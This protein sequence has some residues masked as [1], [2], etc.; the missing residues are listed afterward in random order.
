MILQTIHKYLELPVPAIKPFTHSPHCIGYKDHGVEV[1]QYGDEVVRYHLNGFNYW[2]AHEEI[3]NTIKKMRCSF[4]NTTTYISWKIPEEVLERY[5]E[6]H[7]R[8]DP[9]IPDIEYDKHKIPCGNALD[10]HCFG[11]SVDSCDQSRICNHLGLL[12][13]LLWLYLT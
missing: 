13:Q 12:R 9:V 1:D 5:L 6:I 2:R 11:T 10:Y 7:S 4:N 8:Y 3:K